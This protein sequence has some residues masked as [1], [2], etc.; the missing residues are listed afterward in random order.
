M[1]IDSLTEQIMPLRAQLQAIGQRQPGAR[2]LR[3]HY[4]I[5]ALCAAVI[6][7]ELSDCRRFSNSDQSV[8]FAGLDGTVWSSDSKR[9]PGRLA[10]QG[11]PE[12]RWALFEAAQAAARPCSPDHD[13]YVALRDRL[14][15]KRPALSM[16]R[17]LVRRCRHTLRA[18]GD[19]AWAPLPS[20][21]EM[22][23]A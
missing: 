5:G 21:T 6:W 23:A 11:S 14:G 10:R 9:S 16:A 7:A 12:L 13:Y 15:G 19:E 20:T 4:G 18:L 22:L 8:P 17:K 2:A 1:A 3:V